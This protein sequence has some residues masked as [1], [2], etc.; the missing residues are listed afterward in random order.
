VG[1]ESGA[2][3]SKVA[4]KEEKSAI[5]RKKRFAEVGLHARPVFDP[6]LLL[7]G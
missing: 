3:Q 7:K 4:E 2:Q 6:G 5:S 1:E